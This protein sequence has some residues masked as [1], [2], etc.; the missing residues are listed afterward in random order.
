MKTVLAALVAVAV[1]AVLAPRAP[2]QPAQRTAAPECVTSSEYQQARAA[3]QA[4]GLTR[5]GVRFY[6]GFDGRLVSQEGGVM[7]RRYRHCREGAVS[8]RYRH[9]PEAPGPSSVWWVVSMRR[10]A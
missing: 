5:P 7:K 10:V 3:W 9:F 6:F 2:A 8:V 1:V 4:E